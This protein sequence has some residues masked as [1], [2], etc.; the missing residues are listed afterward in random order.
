MTIS[1]I[2]FDI[3]KSSTSYIEFNINIERTIPFSVKLFD[4]SLEILFLNFIGH[5]CGSDIHK[6]RRHKH[7]SSGQKA[8][9]DRNC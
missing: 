3:Y 4:R 5:R 8:G 9:L 1:L 7:K 2:F 6:K